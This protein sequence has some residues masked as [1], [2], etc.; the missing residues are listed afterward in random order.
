VDDDIG[1][2]ELGS[3]PLGVYAAM[4]GGTIAGQFAGVAIDAAAGRHAMWVPIA[5]SVLLEAVAGWHFGTRA[6]ARTHETPSPTDWGRVSGIYSIGLAAVTVPLAAWTEAYRAPQSPFG[7]HNPS[8]MVVLSLAVL[9]VLTVV[10]WGILVGLAAL[11]ARTPRGRAHEA[12][13]KRSAS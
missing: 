4:F 7:G 6:R 3:F 9:A 11:A 12:E 2:I 5:C 8:G 1:P 10:R 13:E